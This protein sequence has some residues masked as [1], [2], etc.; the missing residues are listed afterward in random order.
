[1]N[2]RLI[3]ALRREETAILAGTDSAA[4]APRLAALRH[5]MRLYDD[6]SPLGARFDALLQER[7]QRRPSPIAGTG[8]A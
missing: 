3:D 1:M 7:P 8:R 6:A 5:L 4:A 2:H